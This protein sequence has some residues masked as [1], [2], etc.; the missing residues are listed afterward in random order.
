MAQMQLIKELSDQKYALDQAAIVAAT[1]PRGTI[2][3]V[4]SKFCEISGYSALELLG[5]NHRIINSGTHPTGFFREMWGE[6]SAGRVWRGE[7]CNRTKLGKLYWVDTT[8]VPFVGED[9]RPYQYLSIRHDITALKLAEQTILQQQERLVA[10]SKLSALGELSSALT[11]E[12]NNPLGVILGRCEMMRALVQSG[13]ATIPELAR[14]VEQV[15]STGK[16]IEKIV[17]SMRAFARGEESESL[18][19]VS[20]GDLISEAKDLVLVRFRSYGI[21]LREELQDVQ[22]ECRQTQVLQVLVNLLNNA[23]DAVAKREN[24][25]VLVKS[26][27]ARNSGGVESVYLQIQ[28]SGPGIPDPVAKKLFTPFFSTKDVQYGTGLGLSISR[29]MARKHHGELSYIAGDG[30]TTFELVLPLRQPLS[31]P[32]HA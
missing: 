1:D 32:S 9:K 26:S 11:H 13:D 20:L 8:I 22:I 27:I 19:T 29:Q 28:D 17:R 18:R 10:A 31:S 14:M 21:E 4:N 2:T 16:R 23:F 12:I 25:W 6:I 5:Q 30:P 7:I 15:E 24:P 3:Y